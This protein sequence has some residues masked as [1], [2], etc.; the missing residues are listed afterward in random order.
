MRK[1]DDF[2]SLG[3]QHPIWEILRV[4]RGLS[5][6]KKKR[7]EWRNL[8]DAQA[9]CSFPGD[10]VAPV[11]VDKETSHLLGLYIEASAEQFQEAF[12][13][14]RTEEEA[15]AHCDSIGVT[16]TRTKTQSADHHQSPKALVGGVTM[17][18][19]EFCHRNRLSIDPN[20]QNRCVW[21]NDDSMHVTARRLDGAIP[22][23]VN[24]AMVWEI[25]EYWGKTSGGSKMSDAVYEC[26]LVGRELRN[27]EAGTGT[28]VSHV[29]FLDGVEQW[30]SRKSDFVRFC[31]LANQGLIDDLI[32]GCE[33]EKEWEELLTAKLGG[34]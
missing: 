1:L 12:G 27:W 19:V 18:A 31:D 30:M 3:W 17:I 33:V 13:H 25:K 8:L 15:L 34:E 32:I 14:L 28:D 9:L 29:V 16:V 2:A 10:E 26:H 22:G 5:R 4:Y 23:L 24:P 20:P 7:H 11:R 21:T 6:G